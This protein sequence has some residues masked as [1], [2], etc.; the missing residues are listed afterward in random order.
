VQASQ[1]NGQLGGRLPDSGEGT[2]RTP[3]GLRWFRGKPQFEKALHLPRHAAM[4]SAVHHR[5]LSGCDSAATHM[6]CVKQAA[7]EAPRYCKGIRDHSL[8]II[9]PIGK[10]PYSLYIRP[11]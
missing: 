3:A 5:M 10:T 9:L 7:G 4:R 6:R 8:T 2:C 11:P 1:G